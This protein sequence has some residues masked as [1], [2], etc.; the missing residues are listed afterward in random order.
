MIIG[1]LRSVK[2]LT[3]LESSK[4]RQLIIDTINHAIGWRK[5]QSINP[6][7]EEHITTGHYIQRRRNDFHSGDKLR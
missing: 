5:I 1:Y 3:I 2:L 7:I 4:L 6:S